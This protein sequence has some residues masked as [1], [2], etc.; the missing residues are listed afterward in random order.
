[1]EFNMVKLIS[2]DDTGLDRN[3]L[4]NPFEEFPG[5]EINYFINYFV[6]FLTGFFK[7]TAD[8]YDE[9]FFKTVKS[10]LILFGYKDGCFFDDQYEDEEEFR[11]AIQKLMSV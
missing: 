7:T 5:K 6:G 8:Q 2:S 1:M 3:V 9:C 11:E 4:L 10:N